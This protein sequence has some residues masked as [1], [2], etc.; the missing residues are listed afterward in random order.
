METLSKQVLEN[1]RQ[2][3]EQQACSKTLPTLNAP[4]QNN[5]VFID[6]LFNHTNDNICITKEISRIHVTVP[7]VE[8]RDQFMIQTRGPMS[9]GYK[10]DNH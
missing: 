2:L 3:F 9:S 4:P 8:K 5:R 7:I 1:Q 6:L 10:T